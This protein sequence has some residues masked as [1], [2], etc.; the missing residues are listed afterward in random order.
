MERRKVKEEEKRRKEV[1]LV[2]GIVVVFM[3]VSV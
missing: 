1:H 2:L 3:Q